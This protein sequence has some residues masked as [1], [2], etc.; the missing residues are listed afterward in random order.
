MMLHVAQAFS[1]WPPPDTGSNSRHWRRGPSSDGSPET[2]SWRRTLGSLWDRQELPL[3]CSPWNSFLPWSREDMCSSNVSCHHRVWYC[4][5]LRRTCEEIC[6]G[7]MELAART[8]R[9]PAESGKCTHKPPRGHNACHRE[10][11]NTP[12]WPHKQMQGRQQGE[13]EAL[14]K[15]ELCSEHPANLRCSGAAC[16]EICPS[17]WSCLGPGIGTRARAPS[18][19]RLGLA[20][21]WWWALHTTMDHTPWG[22][23]DLLWAGVLRMQERLQKP[24][25]VQEGFTAMHWS[26]FLWRRMPVD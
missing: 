8:H 26:V 16:E 3:H 15:E 2:T 10:V 17:G 7:N 9:C 25:Q 18:T 6:L 12:V 4:V 22:I 11:C 20:S 5:S 23:Q 21:E 14:C 13:K 19:N 24:L 1:T